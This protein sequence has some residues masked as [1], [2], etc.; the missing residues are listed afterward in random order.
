[1]FVFSTPA[2]DYPL[3]GTLLPFKRPLRNLASQLVLQMFRI[4]GEKSKVL[5][6]V[7]GRVFVFMMNYLAQFQVSAQ[8]FFHH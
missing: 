8:E 6:S 3:S 5:D 2:L 1:M 4:R 7:I